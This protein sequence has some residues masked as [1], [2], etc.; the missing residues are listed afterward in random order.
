MNFEDLKLIRLSELSRLTGIPYTKIYFR[1]NGVVKSALP[2]KERT[3]IVNAI[4]KE[5]GPL[6]EDLGFDLKVTQKKNL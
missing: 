2:L 4:F 5:I 3:K 1:S 6:F